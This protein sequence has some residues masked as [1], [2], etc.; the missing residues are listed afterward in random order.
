MAK[1]ISLTN[2][3]ANEK[4]VQAAWH[5]VCAALWR[6]QHFLPSV[7][8]EAQH[9]VR[10]HLAGTGSIRKQFVAFCE[11]VIIAAKQAT[12]TGRSL[13]PPTVWLHPDYV[14]GYKGT[15]PVYEKI[16]DT[17]QKI[18]GYEPGMSILAQYYWNRI[19]HWP[20]ASFTH[21]RSRLL[22]LGETDLL[23]LC[24]T[25]ITYYHF[26]NPVKNGSHA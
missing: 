7:I 25:V 20:T 14:D 19:G 2:S 22:R 9:Y 11:R 13:S 18:P 15:F 21:L 3:P 1:V 10:L 24:C 12:Q 23:L 8:N 4:L 17:R 16:C 5:F 6:D 26:L